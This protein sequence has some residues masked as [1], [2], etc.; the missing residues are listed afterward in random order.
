MPLR[1][2]QTQYISGQVGLLLT[3]CPPEEVIDYLHNYVREAYATIGTIASQDWVIPA[4][5]LY[6]HGGAVPDDQDQALPVSLD[7][8]MRNLGMPIR[9]DRGKLMLDQ[10]YRICTEGDVLDARQTKLLNQ[11]GVQLAEFRARPLA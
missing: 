8:K 1:S 7:S 11:F 9:M 4:G 5:L 6:S 10:E 2:G 3:P